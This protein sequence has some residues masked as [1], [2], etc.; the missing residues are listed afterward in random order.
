MRVDDQLEQFIDVRVKALGSLMDAT[1]R[2]TRGRLGWITLGRP[3]LRLPNF[4]RQTP[5]WED[6]TLATTTQDGV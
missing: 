6:D 3:L 2:E 4:T 1:T 5:W